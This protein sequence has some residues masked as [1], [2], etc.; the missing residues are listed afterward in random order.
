MN[1]W[2]A[3]QITAIVVCSAMPCRGKAESAISLL[4]GFDT[5][6]IDAVY[7]PTDDEAAGELAKLAY[8]LRSIDPDAL[9]SKVGDSADAQLGDAVAIDG[10][11]EE[12]QYLKV[13]ARLV[14]VLELSRLHVVTVTAGDSVVQVVTTALPQQA[15]QG[16]HVSGTGVVIQIGSAADDKNSTH[17]IAIASPRLGWF[18]QSAENV[19]WQLLSDAGVDISLLAEVG[20]RNRRPLLS[21]DGNAFYAILAAAASLGNQGGQ[22]NPDNLPAP[23]W[24]EP[25]TLLR[26][27]EKMSGQ[28]VRMDLETV[29]I[30]R[31]AVT[32]PA[33]Q[34]QLGSNHYYQI[35]AV[36]DLGNTIVKIEPARGEEGPPALFEGRYPVSIVSRELPDFLR[37]AIRN[38]E[39]GDAVVSQIKLMVGVDAFFYRLWSY[40]TDFMNQHGSG[41]QFGPLLIAARLSNRE[42]TSS[43]PAGVSTIG[44]IAAGVVI[45][46]IVA[47][48]FWNRRNSAR[49]LEVRQKRKSRESEQLQLP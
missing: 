5:Q 45:L 6:R 22:P 23:G 4:S 25:V 46:S 20:S 8:R 41:E 9:D 30:T 2:T 21:E 40:E 35:D 28:W 39:G 24:V 10:K 49:D 37:R 43:D 31:I 29:Q 32:E 12:I 42:P 38:Q 33:R 36:G 18:P 44:W 16:D 1:R 34:S 26:D 48:W 17:P 19:G 3:I 15:G 11:I 13:P 7:P 14:D 47:M 27:P